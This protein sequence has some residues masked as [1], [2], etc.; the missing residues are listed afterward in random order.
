MFHTCI[1]TCIWWVIPGMVGDGDDTL[2]E[3]IGMGTNNPSP[4]S[5]HELQRFWSSQSACNARLGQASAEASTQIGRR[6]HQNTHFETPKSKKFLRWTPAGEEGQSPHRPPLHG[7]APV[8]VRIGMRHT[9]KLSGDLGGC[10][11]GNLRDT[12]KASSIIWTYALSAGNWLF[13]KV[14]NTPYTR[15]FWHLSL[16]RLQ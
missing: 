10:F 13:N 5:W 4:C 6:M 14:L 1:Y 8:H 9:E 2:R 15:A 11:F 12:C 3:R 7:S 16:R